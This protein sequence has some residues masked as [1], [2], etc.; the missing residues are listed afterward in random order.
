MRCVAM[1]GTPRAAAR[2]AFYQ[3][4]LTFAVCMQHVTVYCGV[5]QNMLRRKFLLQHAAQ[6]RALPQR[7]ASGVN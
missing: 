5:L 3:S 2:L 7:S 4:V 1:R 6:R